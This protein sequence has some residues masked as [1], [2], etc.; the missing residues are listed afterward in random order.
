M[1]L[2]AWN[3]DRTGPLDQAPGDVMVEASMEESES[4]TSS[5]DDPD[6]LKAQ[7]PERADAEGSQVAPS[8]G[9]LAVTPKEEP[10]GR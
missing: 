7:P 2:E 3:K 10:L 9:N 6:D 4:S 1:E 8:E 5:S